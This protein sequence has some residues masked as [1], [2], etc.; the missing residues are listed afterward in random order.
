MS[1]PQQPDA[2]PPVPADTGPHDP[3]SP[4]EEGIIALAVWYRKLRAGGMPIMASAAYMVAF[5]RLNSED[6]PAS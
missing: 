3:M 6:P 4:V 5:Q 1:E 2:V